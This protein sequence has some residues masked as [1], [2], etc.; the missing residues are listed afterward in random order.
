[1]HLTIGYGGLMP[2]IATIQKAINALFQSFTIKYAC[3]DIMQK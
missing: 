3:V 2:S 1:M